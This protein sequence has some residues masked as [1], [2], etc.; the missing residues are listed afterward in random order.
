MVRWFYKTLVVFPYQTA[1]RAMY[2]AWLQ[3]DIPDID[4]CCNHAVL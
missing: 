3:H 2:A 4:P 1:A